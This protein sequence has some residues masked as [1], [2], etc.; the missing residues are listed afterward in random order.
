MLQDVAFR[1][2]REFI[3]SK[4]KSAQYCV[5]GIYYD[6]PV[7]EIEITEQ[8]IVRVKFTVAH[9]APCLISQVRLISTADEVWISKNVSLQIDSS[10]TN[11]LQWFDINIT[12]VEV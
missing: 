9:G 2:L 6:V 4:I 7:S 11:F 1:D 5:N 10:Q 3:K 8:G 12:E